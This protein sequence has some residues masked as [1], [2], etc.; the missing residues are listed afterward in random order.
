MTN[1]ERL[2]DELDSMKNTNY[3]SEEWKNKK[4]TD[5]ERYFYYSEIITKVQN[6]ID[7]D[8]WLEDLEFESDEEYER[9]I[10]EVNNIMS[11][12]MVILSRYE[13]ALDDYADEI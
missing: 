6:M 7:D 10:D 4:T 1:F 11:E 13:Y 9:F 12:A 3:T 8:T 2:I 5:R